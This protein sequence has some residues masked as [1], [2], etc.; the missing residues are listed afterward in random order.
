MSYEIR[1]ASRSE[2]GHGIRACRRA[3]GVRPDPASGGPGLNRNVS[4]RSRSNIWGSRAGRRPSLRPRRAANA[5]A[6]T[7]SQRR[8]DEQVDHCRRGRSRGCGV[9]RARAVVAVE[10]GDGRSVAQIRVDRPASELGHVAGVQTIRDS[11]AAASLSRASHHRQL[12]QA[13]EVRRPAKSLRVATSRSSRRHVGEDVHFRAE[14]CEVPPRPRS[15]P[16]RSTP[17]GRVASG[18][19]SQFPWSGPPDSRTP[20]R[21][22][23]R[24]RI[25]CG[26]VRSLRHRERGRLENTSDQGRS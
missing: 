15:P 26:K 19:A 4:M 7:A 22:P 9:L 10:K 20:P 23:G 11:A 16:R 17:G 3:A 14:A 8:A 2:R 25:R 6:T 18:V 12:F 24:R 1:R 21:C 5:S 13:G